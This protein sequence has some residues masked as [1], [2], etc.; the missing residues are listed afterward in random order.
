MQE[1]SDGLKQDLG[2][3]PKRS[4]VFMMWLLFKEQ[5]EKPSDEVIVQR[6][7]ERFGD[8]DIVSNN[9]VLR[10]FALRSQK[11]F[12]GDNKELPSIVIVS[13]CEEVGEPHGDAIARTQFWDCL[14]GATLLDTCEYQV[15]IGDFMAG[16]LPAIQ[17]AGI[18]SDW[19]E[20][21]LELFPTCAGVY[22]DSSGKLLDAE[23]ARNNPYKDALR[24][25]W[26]GINARNFHIEDTGDSLV[27]TLGLYLL[28]LPDVQ[29]HFHTLKVS[30]V[31][32]HAYNTAIY[33]FENDAPIQSGHT[34][35]GLEPGS[36]WRCQY[37]DALIQPVRQVLDIEAGEFAAGTR[38][39]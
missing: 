7:N 10:M 28:G 32:Q 17:R 14:K 33:L 2:G 12:Y 11:V 37:E 34:I 21:A 5:C 25:F 31:I 16:G 1:N 35:E 29:Y 15:M 23:S 36:M 22:V 20:I 38:G 6:L 39:Y 30:D 27:D 3:D 13:G 9:Q 19:L 24:F 18:L 26:F 8:I 4:G